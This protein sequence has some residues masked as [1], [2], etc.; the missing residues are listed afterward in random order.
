MSARKLKKPAPASA[1][2][3]VADEV[4]CTMAALEGFDIQ[5]FDRW[6]AALDECGAKLELAERRAWAKAEIKPGAINRDA[7]LRHLEWM[8]LRWKY[9][10]REEYILPL[11]RAGKA[12]DTGRKKP[13]RPDVQAWIEAEVGKGTGETAEQLFNRAPEW[14]SDQIA[15]DRFRKRYAVARKNN[16]LVA[17]KKRPK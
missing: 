2:A 15:L 5:G 11:A 9:I 12:I 6:H 4:F 8:L 14:L 17:S 13:K 3:D 16:G 10:K 1:G 7:L